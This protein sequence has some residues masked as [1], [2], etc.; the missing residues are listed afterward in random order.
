MKRVLSM[1]FAMLLLLFVVP[2]TV[3]AA[4]PVTL[5]V[6]ADK[7][8]VNPGDTVN[9]T[10]SIGAVESLGVLEF[11]VKA[12]EGL[13]ISAESVVIPDGVEDTMDSDGKIVKPTAVNGYKWSYTSQDVGYAG[14]EDFVILTFSA[15]VDEAA[16]FEEKEV[17]LEVRDCYDQNVS[18]LTGSVVPAKITV[19]K[20]KIPVTAVTLNKT[21]LAM[22]DGETAVLTATVAPADADNKKVIWS[23]DNEAVAIVAD[24]T[25]TAVA[26]GTAKITVTTED[27]SKNAFCNITVTCAHAMTKTEAVAAT[28]TKDGNTEYYMCGKCHIKFADEV[29]TKEAGDT[30]VKA[31]GHKLVDK[32]VSDKDGHWKACANCT[33]KLEAASHT[34]SWVVDREATEDEVG[35]K[36]EECSCGWKQ[37]ENTEIPKL[38]HVHIGIQHVEAVAA[39]CAKEGTREY[40]TCASAKCAGK[41]Y[42]DAACQTVLADITTPKD[43]NNHSRTEIWNSDGEGHWKRCA[44]CTAKLEKAEHNLYWVV[45]KPATEDEVGYKHEECICGWIQSMGTEIP[46]LDHVHIGIKHVGGVAATCVKE[47]TKAY[48]TCASAKCVGKYYGDAACQTLLTDIVTPKDASNHVKDGAWSAEPEKH[49][50]TCACGTVVE[51]GEHVYDSAMD[52]SCSVCNYERFY[53][54]IS[55]NG[56]DYEMDSDKGLTFKVDGELALFRELKVDGTVVAAEHYSLTEG[57]TIITLKNTY[58]DTLKEG[59]HSLEAVYSDGKTAMA[60]FAVEE[61]VEDD[62]DADESAAKKEEQKGGYI[63]SPKTGEENNFWLGLVMAGLLGALVAGITVAY[64][65]AQK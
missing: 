20:E 28:C 31:T 12:A 49:V 14:T 2:Q 11:K 53:T 27:G 25:V 15:T 45:E 61:E 30:I 62:D 52:A 16:V 48:W 33:A 50:F 24:G 23:S 60:V 22:K 5:T 7:A 3:Q 54:V 34:L 6:K 39:T 59:S 44:N 8:V 42:G 46:K 36:H 56:S 55:G 51:A 19:E 18:K 9:F 4:D 21:G 35:L 37:S 17:T 63:T 57:S 10:V 1:L 26:P 58:L 64:K 65:K 32:W 47:G 40:W 38:D 41:Y 13:T 29:G 43:A